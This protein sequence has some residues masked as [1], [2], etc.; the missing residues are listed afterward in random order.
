M[1]ASSSTSSVSG[2]TTGGGNGGLAS[3]TYTSSLPHLLRQGIASIDPRLQ[4]NRS[5]YV[6]NN[7]MKAISIDHE[8]LGR[9]T[10]ALARASYA[11]G[12]DH[13]AS[14]RLDSV[15]DPVVVDV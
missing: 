15:G 8:A 6:L 3:T 9:E 1:A 13:E 2:G 4:S 10:H 5:F 12:Q 11:Y 14:N 7:A